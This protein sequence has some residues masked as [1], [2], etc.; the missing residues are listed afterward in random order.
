MIR[1]VLVLGLCAMLGA[2]AS[3]PQNPQIELP[4]SPPSGEPAGLVGLS[5][6]NLLNAFG[7]PSFVRKENGSEMWRYDNAN[8][9][10]FFFLYSNGVSQVVRHVETVPHG[11]DKAADPTCL[12]ALRGH[13]P[14]VS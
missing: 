7:A 6:S 1:P 12:D 10:A 14:P 3:E 5:A 9:R 8:C 11:T 13:R 2:C 4:P